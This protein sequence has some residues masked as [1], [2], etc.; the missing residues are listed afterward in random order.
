MTGEMNLR[1]AVPV[2]HSRERVCERIE[3]VPDWR[4]AS[5]ETAASQL[6]QDEEFS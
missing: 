4:S 2:R 5:F 3:D 1:V 6:P